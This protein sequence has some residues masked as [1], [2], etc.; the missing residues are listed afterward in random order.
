MWL[1]QRSASPSNCLA[2]KTIILCQVRIGVFCQHYNVLGRLYQTTFINS[3]C[4]KC[5][6]FS[7]ND[8]A[9]LHMSL[10][11]SLLRK[12]HLLV[13]LYKLSKDGSV[14]NLE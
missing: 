7:I 5:W 1:L 6:Q 10:F 11:I 2:E 3:A 14:F 9:N 4:E 12:K 13:L 8:C